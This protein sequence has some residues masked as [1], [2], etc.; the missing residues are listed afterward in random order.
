MYLNVI[1]SKAATI[2]EEFEGKHQGELKE[3]YGMRA[4]IGGIFFILP[5]NPRRDMS[6]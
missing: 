1:S 5:T 2:R 6:N 3:L 4:R